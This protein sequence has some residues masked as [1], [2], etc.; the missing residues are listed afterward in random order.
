MSVSPRGEPT[1]VPLRVL[2]PIQQNQP[3][4]N[5]SRVL[6]RGRAGTVKPGSSRSARE[7]AM[8]Q[9]RLPPVRVEPLLEPLAD[10]HRPVPPAG[11][12]DGHRQLAA[13]LAA[14]PR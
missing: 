4:Q 10:R 9:P 5:S 7:V 8:D 11:A 14:V 12:A 1:L 13:G 2:L 6:I 3:S